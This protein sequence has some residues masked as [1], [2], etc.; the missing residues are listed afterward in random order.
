MSSTDPESR[1]TP[2]EAENLDR[3]EAVAHDGWSTFLRVGEALEEIRD[4]QL[5]RASHAT[6]EEYLQERWGIDVQAG[7][8]LSHPAG[9]AWAEIVD[10]PRAH[11]RPVVERVDDE[12]LPGLRW[13][14]SQA[15]GMLAD[16]AL[17]L[18]KHAVDIDDH[19]RADLVVDLFVLDDELTTVEALVVARVDWDYELKRFL[20]GHIPPFEIDGDSPA[21][22]E[23]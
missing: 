3:L 12:L 22:D 5:F 6:F 18:E 15:S 21:V 8:P 23:D 9:R 4:R 19:A 16:V 14:L 17:Q 10:G 11:P 1:P 13:L 2:S 20:Q 7:D